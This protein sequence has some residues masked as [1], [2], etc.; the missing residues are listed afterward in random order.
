M[1]NK[2][3]KLNNILTSSYRNYIPLNPNNENRFLVTS[4]SETSH[5]SLKT[6]VAQRKN[7]LKAI[8]INLPATSMLDLTVPFTKNKDTGEIQKEDEVLCSK[9]DSQER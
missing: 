2:K 5:S 9:I 4:T 3:R 1:S 7:N 6:F 8:G